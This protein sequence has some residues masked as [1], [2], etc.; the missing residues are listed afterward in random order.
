MPYNYSRSASWVDKEVLKY[1]TVLPPIKSVVLDATNFSVTD[2]SVRNIVPAGTILKLSST[3]TTQYVA[4]N[5]SGAIQGILRKP[6]DLVASVTEGDVSG[7]M[8]FF[9]CVFATTAIVGFTQYASA[10]VA[11]LGNHNKFE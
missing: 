7:A 8:Y 1:A 10:L 2:L 5:G 11:D 3:N 6:V 4:Y 9:G